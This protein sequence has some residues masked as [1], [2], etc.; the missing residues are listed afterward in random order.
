MGSIIK[1]WQTIE[2]NMHKIQ[3]TDKNGIYGRFQIFFYFSIIND[4]NCK[5]EYGNISYSS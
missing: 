2:R 4:K 1:C 3:T 5:F